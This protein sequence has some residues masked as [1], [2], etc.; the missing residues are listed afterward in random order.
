MNITGLHRIA[1][2]LV[3]SLYIGAVNA[4]SDTLYY[5]YSEFEDGDG[6]QE[7][8]SPQPNIPP[9]VWE[10]QVGGYIDNPPLF[11]ASGT[12][13]A[14]YGY[15]TASEI[16][17]NTLVSP[18]IDLSIAKKPQL[19]FQHAQYFSF[20]QDELYLLFKAGNGASWDTIDRWLSS[21]D[22]WQNEVFNIDQIDA[23]YLCKDFQLAFL[24][25]TKPLGNG[26]AVDSVV[27][28][29][30]DTL[31]KFVNSYSYSAVEQSLI[32]SSEIQVPLIRVRIEI[33]GN[34]GPSD[35]ENIS[36]V[37][38]EGEASYFKTNGF[39]LYHTAKNVFSNTVADTSTQIGTSVSVSSGTISFTGLGQKL[40]LGENYI[41]LTADIAD[42]VNH[43]SAFTIGVAANSLQVNDT[44]LPAAA[45]DSVKGGY[46]EESVFYDNFS[47][48]KGW[49]T[50]SAGGD[51][52]IGVPLGLSSGATRDPEYAYSGTNV[53]GTD[54]DDNGLYLN[55]ITPSTS[56]Y[57]TTPELDLTYYDR[58]KISFRSW[59]DFF[60]D[61][62]STICISND[63]GATWNIIWYSVDDN[64]SF[65][66]NWEEEYFDAT[67]DKYMSRQ[68]SVMLRFGVDQTLS[69]PRAGFNIDQFKI[70]GNHLE[71]DVGITEIVSPYDDC[72]GFGNDTVRIV[73]RNYAEGPSPSEIPVF[74]ALWG[75]DSIVV[76]DTVKVSIPQDDSL[77]FTFSELANFPRGDVYDQFICGIELPSDEDNRN[78]KL[79]KTLYIQD[80]YAP[81]VLT[82]FEYKGGVWIPS[83]EN[84]WMCVVSDG[85]IPV[86][87]ESPHAWI[88][89][90]FGEYPVYDLSYIT[91]GCYDLT[92]ANRNI[93]ELKYW[94]QSD[95]G[96]DGLA[97]EYSVDDG[98]TW[99]LIDTSIY[100]RNWGWYTNPAT[101]LG[102]I[103]WSGESGGWITAKEILPAALASEPKVKFRA[104]WA[105]DAS[106]A[107][108]GPAFNDFQVYPAPPDVGVSSIATP[109]NA[110]ELQNDA[111]TTFYV[112]NYGFNTLP[113]GDT[114]I[115]GV[116]F[117]SEQPVYDTIQ[118]ASDLQ[119]GD[120]VLL[121]V[122][123]DLVL[124]VAGSYNITAYTLI[125]DDPFL[126]GTNNDTAI[127]T[128]TIFANPLV[129]LEDTIGSRDPDTVNIVP[130]YPDWEPGY[131]Y[132]WTP[133]A[134]TDSIYDVS[135]NGFG[136]LVYRL[137]V[138]E[139]TQGCVT[140]DSINVLL[141]YFDAGSDSVV[142]PQTTCELGSE[143]YVTI[144]IK[145]TGTDSILVGDKIQ[146]H[147]RVNGGTIF[148]DTITITEA[149][150]AGRTFNH[151]F[152]NDPF[153]FSAYN[154]Y[155][156]EAWA[157]FGSGD[158]AKYND[159]TY[160][161]V[162]TY[163][164][165][166][167]DLGPDLIVQD[168]VYT[169]NA[170]SGFVTYLW[171]NGD[172]TQTTKINESGTYWVYASDPNGCPGI[173]TV[174]IW[175]K[176]RDIS[177]TAL[178][179]PLTS[180]ERDEESFIQF[181]VSN[182]GTDTIKT[183]ES[184][185]FSYALNGGSKV[186][187][188][189]S[190]STD[191]LPGADYVFAFNKV[192]NLAS[193]GDYEF[194]LTATSA[195]DNNTLNDTI[196]R[197]VSTNPNP[198]FDLGEDRVVTNVQEVLNAGSGP[199]HT[200][201]WMDG[202]DNDSVYL[203]AFSGQY[204]CEVVN[205]NTG[206]SKK[207]TVNLTFDFADYRIENVTLYSSPCQGQPQQGF[208][209]EV[210]YDQ[211][212]N[213]RL[214]TSLSIAV[215]IGDEDPIIEN[216][217]IN[218]L[219]IPGTKET[220]KLSNGI[221]YKNQGSTNVNVYLNGI[222]DLNPDNNSYETTVNVQ[223]EPNVN[224]GEDTLLVGF[225]HLLD[226]GDNFTS[227]QWQDNSTNSTFTATLPGI[228]SVTVSDANGCTSTTSILLV[229]TSI[230]EVSEQNMDVDL[231]PNPVSDKLNI[232]AN[233]ETPEPV[234]F[235]I[236]D[237]TNRVVYSDTH[238]GLGQLKKEIDV[239][240]FNPG[241]YVI[242]I[243]NSE[244]YYINKFVVK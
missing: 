79:E 13:N 72:I 158:T 151:T 80:S 127:K 156:I 78:D 89:S 46:I 229:L 101:A 211:G 27:I 55:G 198:S 142:Y 181:M 170:G 57:A 183:T 15:S 42:A 202:E 161:V 2:M 214:E 152:L 86:L 106:G 17:S 135:A 215:Q 236:I 184:I 159:S 58:I 128:I 34:E 136:P 65:I 40:K 166:P 144:R 179:S 63:G 203:A 223:S 107:A 193:Y 87:P 226:P 20:N 199:G 9:N 71:T 197:S 235:E 227:Y 213:S 164:Y 84:S 45:I 147:Y 221:V 171:S 140:Y 177:A 91:S 244:M 85:S 234:N 67:A 243:G 178:I 81:P 182:K 12:K 189:A 204:Y 14:T 208:E 10:F 88:L 150:Y 4:Q 237:V 6:S 224:F 99:Q 25:F 47:T 74:Y 120:S 11:A 111:T 82:D 64:Q 145:N 38:N 192:E 68:S 97:F 191:I 217:T 139:P 113:A 18:K 35:L 115:V 231:F 185:T 83:K 112:K 148:K 124:D 61:D 41:W 53:L 32:A 126:Y 117:E 190:P 162:E 104:K 220:V 26:V 93:V 209:V 176:I 7:A 233:I 21:I 186:E 222:N 201:S 129:I 30:K 205:V 96:A 52:Q 19:A 118:L 1:F 110:C 154:T 3:L 75:M 241:V 137:E 218:N 44:L 210:W 131:T 24:G 29:E 187:E 70:T 36:F 16:L 103:G 195:G 206:C 225:P 242:R 143:E 174:D 56:Y 155:N 48:F 114:V 230:F 238:Q 121:T 109:I 50:S 232:E 90:N 168:T 153:D 5:I 95:L 77:I 23:K 62:S 175:L 37:L 228:Y 212:S 130:Q 167:L 207:D 43:N 173:D 188:T 60:Y 31:F 165:T 100:G 134:V 8:W 169:L 59:T 94:I 123:T 28:E 163:G 172:T 132:L 196:T 116:D 194:H 119:P 219:W 125:E 180:C 146:A 92:N 216:V 51:F 239:S 102:H 149:L 76:R 69:S 73:L 39:R 160:A 54:L 98:E 33:L 108:R 66:P 141:L 157:H 240:G 133:G 200:Y 49:D 22:E 122:N 105:S 138:T